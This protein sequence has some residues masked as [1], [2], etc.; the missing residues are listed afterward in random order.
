MLHK[1]AVPRI[2]LLFFVCS[3]ISA[4]T[5]NRLDVDVSSVQ[6]VP[7]KVERFDRDFFALNA[8]N[9]S[10]KLPELQK[11]YPGFAELYVRNI[12]CPHGLTDSSCIP[13]IIR[14]AADKDMRGAY[15]ECQK[16]F[17]DMNLVEAQ[18]T[19]VF[20]HYKYYN[21]NAKIPKVVAMMSG[22]N[23]AIATAD[24]SFSVGLEMYLGSKSPFYEMLQFPNYKRVNMRKEYIVSDLVHAWM[25][26]SYPNTNKSGTLL[27]E[28]VYQGKLLY[29][30]DA[31]MPKEQDTIKI[32]FT[33]KQLDWC[34]EN[35]N[36][37]WG[38][39][40][41]NKFLYS[42]DI[43]MVTKFTGEGPFTTGFVKESPGR[44]G[45]WIGWRI[46][47]KYMDNNPKVTLEQLM[48]E[49]DGQ[50]ILAN[51]KYKP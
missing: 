4:C 21:S 6:I 47:R 37:M 29:L 28:M 26:K 3:L 34:M 24:T 2:F 15:D 35:E 39:L 22:F 38:Y 44:T 23:Y 48:Q 5:H 40:I 30:V 13:E 33:K 36:N 7:V 9:I 46:V 27:N 49:T 8:G 12:L 1:P 20:L 11:K 45:I 10:Q 19:N 50:K 41:K 51:S 42:N 18:L 17:P 16:V 43:S 31:L 25:E 14:F 32:G